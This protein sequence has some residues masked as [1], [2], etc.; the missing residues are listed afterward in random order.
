MTL[1]LAPRKERLDLNRNFP[2]GWR[3]EHEQDGAGPFPTSE[4]EVRTA[5]AFVASH[6]NI[7]G[8]IPFHTY[9]GVL[10]RPYSHHADDTHAGRGPLDLSEDSARK[11]RSSPAIRTSPSSTTSGTT[12]RK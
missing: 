4:P 10:L 6:P 5:V 7:T 11:G 2:A 3:Q 8:A 12:P 1:T 9:S